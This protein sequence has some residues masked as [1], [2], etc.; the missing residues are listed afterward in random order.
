[1]RRVIF[2]F[3]LTI[4]IFGF[5]VKETHAGCVRNGTASCTPDSNGCSGTCVWNPWGQSCS[6]YIPP[7]PTPSCRGPGQ[8]CN[9]QG[10]CCNGICWNG[11][12]YASTPTNTPVP[13]TATP[14]CRADEDACTS[15]SQCCSN[16]C[17]NNTCQRIP[18]CTE[19]GTIQQV[20]DYECLTCSGSRTNGFKNIR[21][22]ASQRCKD[23]NRLPCYIENNVGAPV[24]QCPNLCAGVT[25]TPSSAPIQPSCQPYACYDMGTFMCP[26]AF[27]NCPDGVG[28]CDNCGQTDCGRCDGGTT[29]GNTPVPTLPSCVPDCINPARSPCISTTCST[30]TCKGNCN[31][32][33]YG[34]LSCVTPTFNSLEIRRSDW[35]YTDR[36]STQGLDIM[37]AQNRIHT[38][39]PFIANNPN[40]RRLI[41]V[42]WVTTSNGWQDIASVKMRWLG[43]NVV[44]NM[45][46]IIRYHDGDD[47]NGELPNDRDVYSL[48]VDFD[49]TQNVTSAFDH[50]VNITSVNG[51]LSTGWLPANRLLK[52][53]DCNVP[54]SG[55]FYDSSGQTACTMTT[56]LA[57]GLLPSSLNFWA[58]DN[59]TVTTSLSGNN[60]SSANL[61]WAKSYLPLF[62][63]GNA[64]NI[65]GNFPVT[66]HATR[67]NN[68]VNCISG[69]T[70]QPTVISGL[71]PYASSPTLDVDFAFTRLMDPWFQVIGSGL[72]ARN[73]LV[74]GVPVTAPSTSRFLT[75]GQTNLDNGAVFF[76]SV[77]NRNGYNA[78]N[79]YGSPNNWYKQETLGY[80]SIYDYTYFYNNLYIKRGVGTTG[81]TWNQRP[82]SGAFFVNGNLTINQNNSPTSAQ[83]LMVMVKNNL[84]INNNVTD[85]HG[86]FVVDGN[87]NIGGSL[88]SPLNLTGSLYARGNINVSRS[89]IPNTSNNTSPAVIFNYQPSYVLNLP[90]EVTRVIS[91]WRME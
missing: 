57:S 33:C 35:W 2:L 85:V 83:P 25:P 36:T 45:S 78:N 61:H 87:V 48:S 68:A 3:L 90:I 69:N 31:Q 64:S 19:C 15:N 38:C 53:W 80:P 79:A 28:K 41:Y 88:A 42:V 37:D 76:N 17:F 13:P 73:N 75:L 12:C 70:I 5:Y 30:A 40:P 11:Y 71:D 84:I 67:I 43:D 82:A 81:T 14:S 63:G 72:K 51:S 59:S 23:T 77:S 32:Y 29:P 1:M 91:G 74:S 6:C 21:C 22:W 89:L 39:D 27:N 26:Y 62:N 49:A 34:T 46:R 9:S 4:S 47:T 7:T 86:L 20:C 60:Y 66:S 16:N 50:Q 44:R 52:V 18:A 54:I 55:S 10:D 8:S 56:P 65:Y 58:A 24:I